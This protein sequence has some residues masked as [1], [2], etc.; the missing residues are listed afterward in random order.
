MITVYHVFQVLFYLALRVLNLR[1]II[2]SVCTPAFTAFCMDLQLCR[3]LLVGVM[4][5]FDTNMYFILI[6]FTGAYL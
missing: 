4:M 5:T 1:H 2:L 3:G 6:I